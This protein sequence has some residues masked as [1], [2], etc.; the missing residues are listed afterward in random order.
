MVT[1]SLH[2][3]FFVKNVIILNNLLFLGRNILSVAKKA[4]NATPIATA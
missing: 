4:N 3:F 1:H 2:F